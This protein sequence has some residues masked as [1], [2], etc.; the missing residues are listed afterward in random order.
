MNND[1][2]PKPP[3][4]MVFDITRREIKPMPMEPMF[5]VKAAKGAPGKRKINVGDLERRRAAA[6]AARKAR[7]R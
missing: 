7:K 5:Q 3:Q 2:E 1:S 4:P 6:K